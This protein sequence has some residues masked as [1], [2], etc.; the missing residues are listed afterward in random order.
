MINSK[1]Y[2]ELKKKWPAFK[3]L[4]IGPLLK[5]KWDV[6]K[7][8]IFQSASTVFQ[9]VSFILIVRLVNLIISDWTIVIFNESIDF[10]EQKI[11]VFWS[12]CVS[13]VF[14]L[15]IGS[16]FSYLSR[17]KIAILARASEEDIL[18]QV[19]Q[20]YIDSFTISFN[21]N[22]P[23]SSVETLKSFY[24][25]GG[26]FLGRVIM[27]VTNSLIPLITMSLS[28][29]FLFYLRP[30]LTATLLT[31]LLLSLPF[32]IKIARRGRDTSADLMKY[33]RQSTLDKNKYVDY[34]RYSLIAPKG[35]S[36]EGIHWI[37]GTD[38][39]VKFMNAYELRLR[40][41]ALSTFLT[42]MLIAIML[43]AVII[44]AIY[45]AIFEQKST[46]VSSLS[47]IVAFKFFGAGLISIMNTFIILNVFYSY[48]QSMV[49][50]LEKS[51]EKFSN[52]KEHVDLKCNSEINYNSLSFSCG[53]PLA[54]NYS[55][56]VDWLNISFLFNC[57]RS[58]INNDESFSSNRI[59]LLTSDTP[60]LGKTIF[61][62]L[63]IADERTC[64]NVM[65]ELTKLNF[66]NNIKKEIKKLCRENPLTSN[67]WDNLSPNLIIFI[68]AILLKNEKNILIFI[69]GAN[70]KSLCHKS[71]E[72]L[73]RLLDNNFVIVVF[74]GK[75]KFPL[76]NSTMFN[77]M[78]VINPNGLFWIGDFEEAQ[79]NNITVSSSQNYDENKSDFDT[80]EEF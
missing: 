38:S 36:N 67:K 5:S 8:L 58:F 10:S 32:Y 59:R 72:N 71:Q 12:A 78:A 61:E 6:I 30:F 56:Q 64:S 33:A 52:P 28:L 14:F 63:N 37:I 66:T 55:A 24:N 75:V 17:R 79:K 16:L 54:V 1:Y 47:Y 20:S 15:L 19:T 26:R 4:I 22:S 73:L 62:G 34:L 39:T 25:R 18:L 76:I 69:D 41:T 35:I 42:Q 27:A 7:I 21:K 40:I 9:I 60:I 70:F 80:I 65:G 2:T 11:E 74:P 77:S 48:C 46:I 13:T 49:D 23:S 51:K 29:V 68:K 31:L 3:W 45:P 44:S 50:F 53:S 43:T 57:L